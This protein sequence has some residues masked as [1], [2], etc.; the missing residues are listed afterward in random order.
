MRPSSS[1]PR[2]PGKRIDWNFIGQELPQNARCALQE[3]LQRALVV[4]G[5]FGFE[6]LKGQAIA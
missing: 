6:N 2:L 3:D 4:A 5:P 1:K